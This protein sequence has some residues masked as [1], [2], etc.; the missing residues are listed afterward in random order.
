MRGTG[1]IV[2]LSK[3]GAVLQAAQDAW[4]DRNSPTSKPVTWCGAAS[5]WGQTAV[6]PGS[7]E[8]C[9]ACKAAYRADL[10]TWRKANGY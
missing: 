6:T 5:T 9:K 2:H 1:Q 7:I 10:K 3:P 4:R 8:N